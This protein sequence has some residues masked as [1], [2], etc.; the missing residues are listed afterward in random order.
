[1]R[2]DSAEYDFVPHLDLPRRHTKVLVVNLQHNRP[3]RHEWTLIAEPRDGGA[4][5]AQASRKI[6]VVEESSV[7]MLAKIHRLFLLHILSRGE[8]EEAVV[9]VPPR[10]SL[11]QQRAGM[12]SYYFRTFKAPLLTWGHHETERHIVSWR[13]NYAA[14]HQYIYC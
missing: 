1:V 4:D 10:R 13:S 5:R 3:L 2:L 7:E 14:P 12:G 8:R 9:T 6:Y 11:Q